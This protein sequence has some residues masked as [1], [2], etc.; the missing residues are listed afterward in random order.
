MGKHYA[1]SDLH[2]CYDF[3]IAIKNYIGEDDIVF[4]LGDAADRGPQGWDCITGIRNNE[5]FFCLCGNH[6]DML[7]KAMIEYYDKDSERLDSPLDLLMYNG[8]TATFNE[9][10]EEGAKHEW[11]SYLERLP[12]TYI[13]TNL[14]GQK[15]I[16]SH[17]GFTPVTKLNLFP[18]RKEILWGREH[19]KDD[20]VGGENTYIVHGHTPTPKLHAPDRDYSNDWGAVSYCGGHK[21]CIDNGTVWTGVCTLFDLDTFDSIIFK[22][23]R[24]G[25]IICEVKESML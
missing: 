18:R 7:R 12:L 20:W 15:I 14:Q 17:A 3:Y 8:G 10:I 19:F 24:Y 25:N 2:G 21:F 11:I 1:L 22:R 23:N 4:F 6:E 9:W 13:Y 16:L 5:N